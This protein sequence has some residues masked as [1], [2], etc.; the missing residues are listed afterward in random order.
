MLLTFPNHLAWLWIALAILFLLQSGCKPIEA[1][2]ESSSASEETARPSLSTNISNETSSP[3]GEWKAITLFQVP[4]GSDEYYQSLIVS[5][6]S[7]SPSYTLVDGWFPM[8]LGYTVAEPLFWS[9]DGNRFYYTNR[10]NADGC[11][12]LYN[13][14]DL[15]QVDLATGETTELLPADTTTK[16]GLAPDEEHVAYLAIGEPTLIIHNFASGESTPFNLS[17]LMKDAQVGAFVWSP[18]SDAIVFA[19]AHKPCMG[20]WAEATSIYKLD[21]ADM[22]LTL[23]LEADNRLLVPVAWL[24]DN[25][26]LVE[27]QAG[28]EFILDLATD[29]ILPPPDTASAITTTTTM[30]Q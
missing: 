16:L 13:G 1:P 8:A 15:H 24:T 28:E 5:H 2:T 11:A 26:V 20:G 17:S 23:H 22:S 30:S 7:G 29:Q 27:N 9:Y 6:A 4:R 21:A 14:S 3:D 25:F 12:L 10:A 19:V 18:E